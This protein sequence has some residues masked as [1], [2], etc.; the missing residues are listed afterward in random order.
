MI[1]TVGV[2]NAFNQEPPRNGY[3]PLTTNPNTYVN[4]VG[5]RFAYVRVSKGI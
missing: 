4:A 3:D 2:D 5:G 1:F